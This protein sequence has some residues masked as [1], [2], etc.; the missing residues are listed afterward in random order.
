[1]QPRKEGRKAPDQKKLFDLCRF[2]CDLR[3]PGN[4]YSNQAYENECFRTNRKRDNK[5][6]KLI[7]HGTAAIELQNE[8][9]K[10]LFDPFVPLSHSE[11]PVKLEEFDGFT[12]VLITHGHLD[13]IAHLPKI[14][15]RNPKMR[16]YC[17]GVPRRS[18]LKKKIPEKNLIEIHY[19]Q[20]LDV[21][22]FHIQ[23]LH[24]RHAI[25]PS[26]SAKRLAYILKSPAKSNLPWLLK[27][28][29][30]CPEKDET[31]F[32]QIETD[33]VTLSLM[34][35]MNLREEILYPTNADY[36]VL[37]YN[38]W[39]DNYQPAIQVLSR[40]QPKHVL[41]DHYDDT[42]PPL[43]MPLDLSPILEYEKASVRQLE[44][45]KTICLDFAPQSFHP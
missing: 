37:P 17:T 25:L 34:G 4:H 23:V 41:L 13:H 11:V 36:L 1:M 39:E 18:L 15:S 28:H 42:F 16:I 32:Y 38:G 40:L 14:L 45:H 26:V 3:I 44:H 30:S 6:M 24:G 19:G 8:S 21:N 9:G 27:E 12:D 22:G 43:T 29:L 7:W 10:L 5:T 33:N 35:S 20:E 31:V 2:D